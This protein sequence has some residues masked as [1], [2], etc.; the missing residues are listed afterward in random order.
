ME[1]LRLKSDPLG[2]GASVEQS[3]I[4]LLWGDIA[5]H[6]AAGAYRT[7][8]RVDSSCGLSLYF[9]AINVSFSLSDSSG[10]ADESN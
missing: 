8:M 6:G 1:A 10:V 7:S 5:N 4:Q 9:Y 3:E 2:H